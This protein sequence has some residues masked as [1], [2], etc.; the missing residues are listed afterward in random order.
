MSQE[1]RHVAY[2][3]EKL[4]EEKLLINLEKCIFLKEELVYLGFLVLGEGLKRGS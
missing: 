2:F 4:R 3:S 1:G